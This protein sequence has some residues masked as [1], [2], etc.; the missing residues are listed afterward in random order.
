[1]SKET[2]KTPRR[3]TGLGGGTEAVTQPPLGEIS[4]AAQSRGGKAGTGAAKA[5]NMK[6]VK[7]G[8]HSAGRAASANAGKTGKT[9]VINRRLPGTYMD[10]KA[11]IQAFWDRRGIVDVPIQDQPFNYRAH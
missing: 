6:G 10:F 8:I 11:A 1:M 3:V 4:K 5:R 9:E 2:K 7:P